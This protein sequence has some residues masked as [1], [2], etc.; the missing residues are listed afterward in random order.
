MAKLEFTQRRPSGSGTSSSLALIEVMRSE[1]G[2]WRADS[3]RSASGSASTATTFQPRR[4]ISTTSRPSPQPR[5]MTM[6]SSDGA[7]NASS[8][9]STVLRGGLS[10]SCA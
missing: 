4:T 7:P 2:I 1:S 10:R 9:T 8:A 6:L 3:W 5:S